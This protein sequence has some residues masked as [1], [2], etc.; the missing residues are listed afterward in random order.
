MI[1][2]TPIVIK[3]MTVMP[4]TFQAGA[5]L[6]APELEA[7]EALGEG[8]ENAADMEGGLDPV[9]VGSVEEDVAA[10]DEV[11][12]VRESRL[13]VE[14]EV[15]LLWV[16]VLGVE[17]GSSSPPRIPLSSVLSGLGTS[18]GDD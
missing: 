7:L 18:V 17:V 13:A 9:R 12:D 11:M 8:D 5:E 10:T 3:P 16:V 14:S 6:L 2:S 1:M 15:D 4:M